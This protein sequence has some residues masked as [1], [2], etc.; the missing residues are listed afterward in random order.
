MTGTVQNQLSTGEAFEFGA[1]VMQQL[2]R[3]IDPDKARYYIANKKQLGDDLRKLGIHKIPE[4][5]TASWSSFYAK[6]FGITVC[7]SGLHVP[8]KPDYVCRAIVI[9][10]GITNNQVFDAC[11]KAF[12]AWRYEN[13]LDT[14]RDMAKRPDGPYVV[15]VR[16]V[17]EADDDMKNKSA[18][19]IE[20]AGIC[21]LTLKERMIL[22]IAYFDETG[23]HLD[24]NNW[25]L[26]AGSRGSGGLVPGVFW[27]DDELH[28]YWTRVGRR[29]SSLRARVVVS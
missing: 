28:V 9:V 22:E 6:H 12:K 18:N 15:W 24:I 26:C 20:R 10:P 4:F 13:D 1:A 14:V 2:G 7:L 17:V 11:T 16:D 29:G 21:T 27:R 3:D 19:D 25:T 23:K 5:D 8:P